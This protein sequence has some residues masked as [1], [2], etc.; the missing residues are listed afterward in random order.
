MAAYLA[1]WDPTC[2]QAA[3][4]FASMTSRAADSM[5]GVLQLRSSGRITT[6][7]NQKQ[8]MHVDKHLHLSAINTTFW[9]SAGGKRIFAQI[10]ER[11]AEE[12]GK[13]EGKSR[14][15]E[16]CPHQIRELPFMEGAIGKKNFTGQ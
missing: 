10:M 3:L 13:R 1:D 7:W 2:R 8:C 11:L 4:K 6:A 5:V 9:S 16:H 14:W 12:K 15:Q